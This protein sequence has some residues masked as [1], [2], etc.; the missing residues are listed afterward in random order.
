MPGNIGNQ[1]ITVKFFDPVDSYIANA[2]AIGVRKV[3]IYIGGY[4]AKT[5]DTTITISPFDCEI[6]DGTYQVRGVTG[7]AVSVIVGAAVPYVVLR[8]VYTGDAAADYIDFVAVAS[9]GLLATDVIVGKCVF[10][11]ATLT[12]FD[13]TPRTT[14]LVMDLFMKVEP[15]VPASMYVRVRAGRV[16]YGASTLDVI[17]QLSPLMAAPGIGSNVYFIQVNAGGGVVATL[18]A[19]DYGGLVTLAE[20]TIAAGQTTITAANIRDVRSFGGHGSVLPIPVAQGGTGSSTQNFVDLTNPQT[21]GGP[22]TFSNIP[23]FSAG[24]NA[25]NQQVTGLCIEN[26]TDDT[27]CTQTGR[28]WLRTDL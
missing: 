6:G 21:V 3:G 20:I 19:V 10:T 23:V 8:W 26:R 11:G 27:G 1:V 24:A 2:I 9:G 13:Y 14:P 16:T 28:I 22:K 12:G 17:D 18:N 5:N 4:L 7:S 25:N 15:T